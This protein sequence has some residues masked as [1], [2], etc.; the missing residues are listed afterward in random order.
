MIWFPRFRILQHANMI[1]AI[2]RAIVREGGPS[3]LYEQQLFRAC[4]LRGLNV[5]DQDKAV[6][7]KYLTEWLTVTTKLDN[8][9][10]SLLLHLPILLGYNHSS[11]IWDKWSV[12]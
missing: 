5:Q 9:S 6:M 8:T 3:A 2:D 7:L 12:H 11:R 10:M 4:H 1:H